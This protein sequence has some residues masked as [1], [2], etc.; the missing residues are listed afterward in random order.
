MRLPENATN[1]PPKNCNHIHATVPSLAIAL[2]SSTPESVDK[3]HGVP[4]Q[5]HSVCAF[6]R[7][8]GSSVACLPTN[9]NPMH[10]LQQ[11]RLTTRLVSCGYNLPLSI[12]LMHHEPSHTIG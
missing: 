3:S 12:E 11:P 10:A 1:H 8:H 2:L 5:I 4:T 6:H 9:A 7:L